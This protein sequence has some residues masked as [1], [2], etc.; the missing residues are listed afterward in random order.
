MRAGHDVSGR[1]GA[2]I[3]VWWIRRNLEHDVLFR[4][5]AATPSLLNE[6][7]GGC[8][9]VSRPGKRRKPARPRT[10]YAQPP[11]NAGMEYLPD[12]HSYDLQIPRAAN[13]DHWE[14]VTRTKLP[15]A[16]RAHKPADSGLAVGNDARRCGLQEVTPTA[17][18][19]AFQ[20]GTA[21]ASK[22]APTVDLSR[23]QT[24][25]SLQIPVGASLLAKND[26]AV[27]IKPRW[28]AQRDETTG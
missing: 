22:L 16:S 26:N 18:K 10:P 19:H 15:M 25:C 2:G 21:I 28:H 14:S 1:V 4:C 13:P 17:V 9:Q 20:T 12:G 27:S 11:S 3:V 5:D 7:G 8:T 6:G 24:L 23:T